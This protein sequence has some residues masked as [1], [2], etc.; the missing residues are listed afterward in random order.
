MDQ[1]MKHSSQ[2]FLVLSALALG[3]NTCATTYYVNVANPAPA[4]PFTNWP[5]AATDIQSAIDVATN[6]DIVLVT[7]GVYQTGGRTVNGY[8]LTNRVVV[9][10]PLT[11]Q[12]VNG[13]AITAI[14]GYQI[15]GSTNGNAAVRCIYLTNNA[16]LSG[17]TLTSGATRQFSAGD[18]IHEQSGA[19]VWC[20]STNAVLSN[21]VVIA[22]VAPSGGGGA[23]SGTLNNCLL[24]SNQM[25]WSGG[26][27]GGASGSRL[28]HCTLTGNSGTSGGGAFQSVLNYCSISNNLGM[29]GGGVYGSQLNN[30]IVSHN[31]QSALGGSGHGGGV[32]FGV[33][34]NCT[35][36]GNT[37][38]GQYGGIYGG[39]VSNCIIYYNT[40]KPSYP[41]YFNCQNSSYLNY[42]C[43]TPFVSAG[44]GNITN[45]PLF[46]NFDGGDYQLL[47]NSACINSGMNSDVIG[48]NDFDGNPRIVGGTV[49]IGA[50]EFQTP[51]SVLSYAW[52]QQY[53][54]PTDGS[55]DFV[56]TDGDGFNNWQEWIAGTIPTNSASLLQM[57]SASNSVSGTKV[58][59]QSVTGRTYFLLR[60][61]NLAMQP[62][63]SSIKTNLTGLAGA[64][65]F[66]DT[67][68]T[69][70][71]SFFYRVGVQ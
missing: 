43:T 4:A 66:T 5:T 21:C 52:A 14:Q 41:D 27:G 10:K 9:T 68:A 17:F 44:T 53:G 63:F 47:A 61:T 3:L 26:G 54:L 16:V 28:N 50:Y 15:P 69:N 19:G 48:T 40:C 6:G 57:L 13:P 51:T 37:A 42:C 29:A 71:D 2:I 22:N 20:E 30:C 1:L 24:V 18:I 35:I 7:N 38:N 36:V 23:Y 67:T 65:S 33:T 58:T 39:D 64:T 62:V 59:W 34:L 56:D 55:A 32:C 49:D 8:A 25:T 11:I 46:A 70:G 31:L 12:S 60:G 45:A